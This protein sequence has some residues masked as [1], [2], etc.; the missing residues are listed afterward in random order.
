MLYYKSSI[1]I[2]CSS[3]FRLNL[4]R[5]K[6][7]LKAPLYQNKLHCNSSIIIIITYTLQF[8]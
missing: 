5:Q 6:K 2:L 8:L 1:K 3:I 4:V 7:E